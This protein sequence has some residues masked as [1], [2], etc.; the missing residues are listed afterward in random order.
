MLQT[1]QSF[2][3]TRLGQA[4]KQERTFQ[5]VRPLEQKS[6]RT[7]ETEPSH[8]NIFRKQTV[9]SNNYLSVERPVGGAELFRRMEQAARERDY[10]KGSKRTA[11]DYSQR[12]IH[13]SL[14]ARPKQERPDPD[15]LPSQPA[16]HPTE[17]HHEEMY[18]SH[19]TCFEKPHKSRAVTQMGRQ[20]H[21]SEQL[22][23]TAAECKRQEA[24]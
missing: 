5:V 10:R 7:L 23:R 13:S 17:P 20:P 21:R 16:P 12:N 15:P 4:Q 14:L 6:Y 3:P 1:E 19:V 22:L 8:S 9:P 11:K 24:L 18:K 2:F